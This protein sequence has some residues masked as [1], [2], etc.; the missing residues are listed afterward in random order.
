MVCDIPAGDGNVANL[1]YGVTSD[2]RPNR[3]PCSP[4]NLASSLGSHADY[5]EEGEVADHLPPGGG[6]AELRLCQRP[7]QGGQ[8]LQVPVPY[9]LT[10]TKTAVYLRNSP[11][12]EL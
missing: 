12:L 2:P 8:S 1:F 4:V 6:Q 9:P 5:S 3:D 7:D 11:D 10:I